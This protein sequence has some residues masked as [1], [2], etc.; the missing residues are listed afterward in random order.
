MSPILPGVFPKS[1]DTLLA[2]SLVTSLFSNRA[3]KLPLIILGVSALFDPM[4]DSNILVP[5]RGFCSLISAEENPF[6]I[7]SLSN[8]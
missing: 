1:S 6:E 4:F 3:A 2:K 7:T 8:S 5:N